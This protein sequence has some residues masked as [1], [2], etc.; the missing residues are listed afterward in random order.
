MVYLNLILRVALCVTWVAH[1]S[2]KLVFLET[3]FRG[4]ALCFV[5]ATLH[6]NRTSLERQLGTTAQPQDKNGMVLAY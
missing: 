4:I 5:L 6:K 2:L 3:W 1:V